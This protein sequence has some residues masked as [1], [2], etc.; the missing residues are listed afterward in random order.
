MS[1]SH[2][3]ASTSTGVRQQCLTN[4]T[5]IP[6]SISELVCASPWIPEGP[7]QN[8]TAVTSPDAELGCMQRSNMEDLRAYHTVEPSSSDAIYDR[9][10]RRCH[11]GPVLEN[12]NGVFHIAPAG[13]YNSQ[14]ATASHCP[15]SPSRSSTNTA[16]SISRHVP[17]TISVYYQNVRGLRTKIT[18]FY[19]SAIATDYDV[20]VL[21]E[22]WLNDEICSPQL[23]GDLYTV[24]RNDRDPFSTGKSRGGGVLIA[25]STRLTSS[26]LPKAT[27]QR[28]EQL[29]VLIHGTGHN[30]C[31][32]VVYL[33]PESARTSDHME[34]LVNSTAD[35]V[36]FLKP[37][38]ICGLFGDF[39]QPNL[40]WTRSNTRHTYP[41]PAAS[42]FPEH[43]SIFLDGMSLLGMKQMNSI[44]NHRNRMLDLIFINEDAV[45]KCEV[46]SAPEALID[47]DAFHPPL[48]TT[49]ACSAPTRFEDYIDGR[50]YNFYKTDFVALTHDLS[51][52]DWTVIENMSNVNEAVYFFSECLHTRFSI[53]VPQPAPRRKPPWSNGKLRKLKRRR[54]AALRRYSALRSFRNRRRFFKAST[55]YKRYNRHLYFIYIRRIQ[56]NLKQHPKRFW[57]FVNDKRSETGLP[58]SMFL[59]DIISSSIEGTCDLFANHFSSVFNSTLATPAQISDALQFVPANVIN[60]TRL[61]F[62]ED[63]VKTAC[64]NMKS[65]AGVGPDGI[66][67]IIL[68]YCAEVLAKP[69][70]LIF[71]LSVRTK[72]FP[73]IW[74][75]SF[76]FPVF[77]KGNKRDVSNY[78]G[79]TSL[80]ACSKLIEIIVGHTFHQATKSYITTDQHG[81]YPGRSTNSNLVEFTSHCLRNMEGGGQVDAVYTDLKAAFDS[82][83]HQ[84][85]L[86]KLERL[87]VSEN[88]VQ[89]ITSFL[90]GRS[91]TVKLGRCES[92]VFWSFSGVSQGSNIGPSFFSVYYN[93]VSYV[94]PRG[95]RLLYADDLK[96]Y[97][98]VCCAG[99]C[100]RLQDL[101]DKFANWCATNLLSLSVQKCQVITFSRKK[102]PLIWPYSIGNS[103][104]E[105]ISVVK[106][107]GVLLDS[108][109]TFEN[110]LCS[111]LAKANRNLGFLRRMTKEFR[112]TTCLCALFCALVRSHLEY[113][114]VVWCPFT[115][116]YIRRIESVQSK[117]TRFALR[118]HQW[119]NSAESPTYE[120]RCRALGL[121]TLY[122][123]REFLKASF[124]GKLLLG[125]ID[126]PNILARI[127]LNAIPRPLRTRSILR[128]NLQRTRYGQNEPIRA[129][130]DAFNNVYQVFDFSMSTDM[131]QRRLRNFMFT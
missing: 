60:L 76:M 106:D 46:A 79:I 31:I 43:S 75:R 23:F 125:A 42:T 83:N 81:F 89:W 26:E 16:L 124:V 122:N 34:L 87:G 32:G 4:R 25:V 56:T 44:T 7:K 38:D 77:K 102:Q 128:L 108:K 69:L 6:S 93:D 115:N 120:Q 96:L 74:K 30:V 80:C 1:I 127:N 94:I 95:C 101:I 105:R 50:E 66:P 20:V 49:F 19:L 62:S 21:T 41:D 29:W 35:V 11:P 85:L 54:A 99:D 40:F 131:F 55:T 36:E 82:I 57:S 39:N 48:I 63:E 70:Q 100:R 5:A 45:D 78:R 51:L 68:K 59:G 118:F 111:V 52:I 47:V 104:L 86:A 61:S 65:S 123:R 119:P 98:T 92:R 121:A 91:L 15:Q 8:N 14:S 130:C 97:Q 72:C 24:Y 88:I 17:A 13:E 109:L 71:D 90:T 64:R 110:H 107:L 37:N 67:S 2:S 12:S 112:D 28:L 103:H 22:T 73:D 53:Y 58:E 33:S 84:I 117:F 9:S 114:V 116:I 27:N 126:A 129:I 10:G 18:D 3:T 113:A